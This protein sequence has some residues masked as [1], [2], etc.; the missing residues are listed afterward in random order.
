MKQLSKQIATFDDE[1]GSSKESSMNEDSG[2]GS[3]VAGD[4]DTLHGLHGI[5]V[6]DIS[7]RSGQRLRRAVAAQRPRRSLRDEDDDPNVITEIVPI[8]KMVSRAS[9][10]SLT[11]LGGKSASPHLVR[12]RLHLVGQPVG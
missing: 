8:A 10:K 2:L 6:L 11:S 4:T 12:V 1:I 7:P 3:Q 9:L 5:D